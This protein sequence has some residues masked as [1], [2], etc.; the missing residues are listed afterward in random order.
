[1]P[2][3]D[4]MAVGMALIV[5]GTLAVAYGLMPRASARAGATA[6]LHPV[7]TG[8]GPLTAFHWRLMLV[9]AFALVIDMMK[10]ATLG[11]VVPGVAKEYGLSRPV[12]AL[13]PFVG[14][15]GTAIGSYLWGFIGDRA[16]R[17]AA[18]LLAAIMFVGTSICGAMPSFG[19]NLVMCFIMGLCAGGLLPLTYTLLA[20]LVP[21]RH[22]GWFLVLLGGTG[23]L[24][25]YLAASVSATLLEP[26]F[27]WRIM[28]FLGLPTGLMLMLLNRYIPESP[29]FLLLHGRLEEARGIMALVDPSWSPER[30]PVPTP[31]RQGPAVIDTRTLWRP[32]YAAATLTLNLAALAWG[33][34]NYGFLLWLPAN[35][36][37]QGF[38]V[39]GSDSL[40]MQS[41]LLS[42]PT[43]A[44]AAWLYQRWSTKWTLILLSAITA[45]GLAGISLLRQGFPLIDANPVALIAMLMI[46]SGGVIAVILPY[47]AESYPLHVRGRATGLVAG[48]SK[49]GGIAAQCVSMAAIVPGLATAAL[50]LALPVV[51]SAVL[52]QR[53]GAET[54]GRRLEELDV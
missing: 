8:D 25:G 10:P 40:L 2:M 24:G 9:L 16:G 32:P 3:D 42:L 17:R 19:W 36:R 43:T 34:V 28:W 13:L 31:T 45:A 51:I 22:R 47:S 30:E 11:F 37:A 26:H 21:A 15:T 48:S 23:L 14:L 12:V 52:V 29:G 27:G 44:V 49:V 39:A 46:G 53:F 5:G 4:S 54:R 20:E 38:S 6:I 33:L 35:L 7:T 1:M 41:A 18:I 50:I